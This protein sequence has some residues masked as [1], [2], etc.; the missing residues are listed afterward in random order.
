VV[1]D[2]N[3]GKDHDLSAAVVSFS[4][5]VRPTSH[6]GQDLSHIVSVFSPNLMI[7]QDDG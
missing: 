7:W 4:R 6:K 3:A 1:F 2:A 5:P